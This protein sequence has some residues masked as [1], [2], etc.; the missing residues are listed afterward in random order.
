MYGGLVACDVMHA[1]FI[2]FCS[3]FLS[4]IHDCLTPS[5]KAK[6]D[7]RMTML[8]GRFRNPETGET[9]RTPK[10][11]ITSQN[12]LTAELR[13]LAVFL[14]MHVLGSQ[15]SIL[16][17]DERKRVRE[18]VLI[19]GSSLILILTSV[20]NKRPYTDSEW[21]EIFGPVSLRFFRAI[22]S[23]RHWENH[24]KVTERQKYNLEHPESPKKLDEFTCAVPDRL[25]SSDNDTDDEWRSLVGFVDRG[26]H[27]L[28]HAV[29]HLKS[30]V[31]ESVYLGR[32]T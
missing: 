32:F 7:Q 17:T 1:I 25:D 16:D 28:P 2:N 29:L 31:R 26:R 13:V 8:W 9:S 22:D 6:L 23:I 12:G 18:H 27:I 3:Y 19:A 10:E 5:M 30:Q 11:A 20:R 14:L 21:D 15:A 4:A 24:R